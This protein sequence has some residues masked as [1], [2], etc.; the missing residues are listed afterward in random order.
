MSK[1][2]SFWC[3]ISCLTANDVISSLYGFRNWK[4]SNTVG[5]YVLI[6]LM[7]YG[8]DSHF[9]YLLEYISKVLVTYGD[10]FL[11]NSLIYPTEYRNMGTFFLAI[12]SCAIIC[13]IYTVERRIWC[14]EYTECCKINHICNC[15]FGRMSR[16]LC[17]NF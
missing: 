15:K 10:N 9:E 4:V 11:F 2:V 1:S 14:Q 7:W 12:L 6:L 13:H 3:M 17:V 5:G 8:F 16:K